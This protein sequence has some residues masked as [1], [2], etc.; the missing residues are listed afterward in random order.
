MKIMEVGYVLPVSKD[1]VN[2]LHK[3]TEA[4][5][6]DK[7]G[8]VI[9]NFRDPQYSPESGGFHP[10]EVM[11]SG[12]GVI[13]YIT[14]FSYAGYPAELGKAIDFDFSLGL[15]QFYGLEK[16][17]SH[18]HDLFCLWQE[19]FCAYYGWGTYTVTVQ[20]V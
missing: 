3:E 10:V 14:D 19:N 13:Q 9:L 2:I 8:G 5:G 20:G 12:D 7:L 16:P 4:S 1:L 18:G 11:V 15:F 6:K 17:I